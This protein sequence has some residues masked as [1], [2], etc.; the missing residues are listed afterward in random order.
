MAG[1]VTLSEA[2]TTGLGKLLSENRFFVPSH[3]RDYRWDVD[4]V[5][6]LFDDLTD[7]MERSDKFYFIGLMVFMHS[8]DGRLRVLDGQQR[9]ATTMIMLS[10]IR[11]WFGSAE[12]GSD[13]AGQIQRDFIGRSEYGQTE[14]QPKLELN[15]NNDGHFQQFV[16]SGSPLAAIRKERARTNKNAPNAD[17]L[18]SITYCHERIA[19]L[20]ASTSTTE[21]AKKFL[22]AFLIF[23]RDSVIAV[24]LTVPNEGNAFR[25]FETLNDRGLDLSAIDLLKN[26]LFG[27][28]HD[29]SKQLLSQIEARWV[30]ITQVLSDQKEIDFLK[31]YWTSRYGRTQ[32]ENIFDDSRNEIKT[33]SQSNEFTI[34]FLEAAEYYIALD[35][36]EDP[37]WSAYPPQA[38]ERIRALRLIGSKQ[39]RPVMLSALQRFEPKEFVRLL[40][41]MEV[42]SVRWQLIGG[43]RTGAL[44]IQSARLAA[45]IWTKSVTTASEARTEIAS[46]YLS[47]DEFR[48]AFAEKSNLTNQKAAFL[49]RRLEENERQIQLGKD[50]AELE[51][52]RY[53]TL[54]HILPKNP[55]VDWQAELETDS[56][57]ITDCVNRLGNLCLLA[58][59]RNKEAERKHFQEKREIYRESDLFLTKKIAEY[60]DWNRDSIKHYQ[61]WL[62][63]RAVNVWRFQ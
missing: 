48:A 57:L 1:I 26:Y 7:A 31:V 18:N 59:A 60:E 43:G 50:A 56:D 37:I 29:V 33:G 34:D 42:V 13:T 49:L 25:V 23:I 11:A 40:R 12:G 30:Q 21:E 4:R 20:A 39:A 51:P 19:E 46:V 9:L 38:R 32:L 10:A 17:L 58:E 3:Q 47:D 35:S 41:L 44:E 27:L 52:G 53:A 5:K 24:R 15:Y 62:A 2:P 14:V 54:E 45:R 6:K 55:G 16:V 36:G 8:D 61:H 63:G 22:N 28:A